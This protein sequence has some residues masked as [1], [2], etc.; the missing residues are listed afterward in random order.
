S[1]LR[2][3]YPYLKVINGYGPTENTTFSTT[4]LIDRDY[5]FNIPIGKPVA[6]STVYIIDKYNQL[7]P[8][9][10]P[11]EL[12]VGGYGVARGYLNQPELTRE[13]FGPQITLITQINRIQKTKINKSFGKSRNPFSK[14]FLAAG[15]IL[16][17]TGDL[18]RWLPDGNL[19]F[20]GRID[21]QV[22]IRGF[23][24]E[25]G[26]IEY[27]LSQHPDIKEVTVKVTD[28]GGEKNIYA[29][30]VSEKEISVAELKTYLA[31]KLPT[32]MIPSHFIKLDK[33][34]LTPNGKIDQKKLDSLG[35]KLGTGEDFIAPQTNTEHTIA[36][37][38][39]EIL[40]LEKV[41]I[42]DNFFDLGGTSLDVIKLNTKLN[43]TFQLHE[44]IMILFRYTTVHSYA[45]YLNSIKQETNI[46]VAG[47][48]P[49][50][51]STL[52][53]DKV[54]ESRMAQ[55]NKRREKPNVRN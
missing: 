4:F 46:D 51:S 16:Y 36:N 40:H 23:R 53:F 7:Q 14:G 55:R 41:G 1:R 50:V 47:I 48:N 26:E 21:N 35:I 45:N 18:A 17:C 38:W 22:K 15:G 11:G 8:M 25:L 42:N 32:H 20:L 43:E 3:R 13:K 37:T 39:K 6:N 28:R 9:G 49:G 2:H 27:Q 30:L 12:L 33:M 5:A 29:Y 52:T 54:K 24:I 10:V 31:G 44:S 34:P 19:E